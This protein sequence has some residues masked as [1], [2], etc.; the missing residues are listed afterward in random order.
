M[1][2]AR[3]SPLHRRTEDP[4]LNQAQP[5][6]GWYPDPAGSGGVRWWDGVGWTE[7]VA[8][9]EPESEPEPEPQ[10]NL[11]LVPRTQ[12]PERPD[13]GQLH[14]RTRDAAF[15]NAARG[16]VTPLAE[17]S[18]ITSDSITSLRGLQVAGALAFTI[19]CWYLAVRGIL[20]DGS[21]RVGLFVWLGVLVPLLTRAVVQVQLRTEFWWQWCVSRGF[22]PGA[23]D[24]PGRI[25]PGG[26]NRSPL[27]GPLET[28]VI[29]QAAR[30]RMCGREAIVGCMLRLVPPTG[31]EDALATPGMHR[32]SF[33]VMPI[34]EVAAARWVGASIRAD[35]HARR[36]LLH[37]AM[38]GAL[39]ASGV[40]DA[41]S[42]LTAA[43]GQ[44]QQLLH[45]VVDARLEQYL[46][47]RPMDVDI[48]EDLLVVTRDGA[49]ADG[50][51]LDEL[52]RDALLLHE[53]LVAEHE[54]PVEEP[55]PVEVPDEEE[56]VIDLTR[57][58]WGEQRQ[59]YGDDA[60]SILAA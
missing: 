21:Y 59:E 34:P 52:C 20:G 17:R 25:L 30:R 55:E 36:P 47:Q 3:G 8:L 58:G 15:A 7:H 54:L 43:P 16:P 1:R 50:D 4:A 26:L 23:A 57:A 18:R 19:L 13:D 40:P 44:D 9:P 28:R 53:L 37:R 41:R 24:G 29:E 22:D 12:Q 32:A 45:R 5:D 6:P 33:V 49:P 10:P 39:V 48:V 2:R 27:F 51:L 42:H 38:I 14:P 60:G 46:Q 11:Y 31:E 56:P 35:H